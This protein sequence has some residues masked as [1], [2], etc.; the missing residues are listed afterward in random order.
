MKP[1]IGV[2]VWLGA[3]C[4]LVACNENDIMTP[5][6]GGVPGP[7]L[8]ISTA[9]G[10]AQLYSMNPDGSDIRRITND[11]NFPIIN[12]RWSPDGTKIVVENPTGGYPHYGA[13]LFV[14]TADGSRKWR[15][16]TPRTNEPN[17]GTG[18]Y[19]AWSPDSRQ[20]AFSRLMMPEAWANF[21]MFIINADGSGERQI[22]YTRDTSEF[23]GDW[24]N[25]GQ[26]ILGDE[27]DWL[28]VDSLGR[29]I[30]NSRITWFDLEG[31]II[32]TQ[33]QLGSNFIHPRFSV[34][35]DRITYMSSKNWQQNIYVSST[36]G[37]GETMINNRFYQSFNP[38]DWSPDDSLV[39]YNAGPTN[40]VSGTFGK[41]LLGNVVT[42]VTTDITPWN[43]S[44]YSYA[45][46]W[47]R[48]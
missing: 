1:R 28:T 32:R 11:P 48:R 6:P 31:G 15:L 22:T 25:D 47:R 36:D 39:L 19:A 38:V 41:I 27:Y 17:Y 34:R 8:F 4:A 46:S 45:V 30:A 37:S 12:A 7:I 23:V 29:H 42:K 43:D 20:I 24:S 26:V 9:S 5:F 10:S 18:G 14:M 3:V 33:G 21:D 16:S 35:G 44:I 2:M 40:Y 13:A